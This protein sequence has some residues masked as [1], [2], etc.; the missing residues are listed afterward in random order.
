MDEMK[1]AF[2]VTFWV[3]IEDE[4]RLGLTVYENDPKHTARETKE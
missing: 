2:F 4:T 3:R 1:V